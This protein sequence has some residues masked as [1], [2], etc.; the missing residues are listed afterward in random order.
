MIKIE[1]LRKSV[2]DFEDN[3]TDLIEEIER[4]EFYGIEYYGSNTDD[5]FQAG[6]TYGKYLQERENLRDREHE[7]DFK[8]IP[9]V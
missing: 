6:V 8:A 4:G 3:N 7:E 9:V 5:A 1:R 2:K